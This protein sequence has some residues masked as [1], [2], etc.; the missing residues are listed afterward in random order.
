VKRIKGCYN[1]YMYEDGIVKPTKHHEKGR[2]REEGPWGHNGGSLFKVHRLHLWNYHSEIPLYFI[3][4]YEFK[5]K[6][7]K[8]GSKKKRQVVVRGFKQGRSQAR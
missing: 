2:R 5:V 1:T 7:N 6:E 3:I 8:I 4:V